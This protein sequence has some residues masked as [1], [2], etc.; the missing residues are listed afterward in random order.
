ML[1]NRTRQRGVAAIEFVFGF[2]AFWIMCMAWAEMSYMSYISA[3]GDIAIAEAS[4]EAK[5]GD[6]ALQGDVRDEHYYLTLFESALKDNNSSIWSA[7]ANADNFRISI[8]YLDGIDELE[9]IIECTAD[10]D[11]GEISKEC[12]DSASA[13]AL[14]RI[15]YNFTPMFTYFTDLDSIFSREMFV[16]QEYERQRVQNKTTR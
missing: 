6:G 4:R 13:I 9:D 3:I 1:L 10:D 2:M 15:S 7:I 5:K 12:G 11:A 16:V 14:Y 8:Q